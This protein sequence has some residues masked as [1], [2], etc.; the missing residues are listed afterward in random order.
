MHIPIGG[1]GAGISAI[2]QNIKNRGKHFLINK[3]SE[4]KIKNL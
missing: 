3:N 4:K 1:A 2:F